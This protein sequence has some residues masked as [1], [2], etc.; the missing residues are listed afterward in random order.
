MGSLAEANWV[1]KMIYFLGITMQYAVRW[2]IQHNIT[3]KKK[4]ILWCRH[5]R[6]TCDSTPLAQHKLIPLALWFTRCRRPFS[7]T[8]T[9]LRECCAQ[10]QFPCMKNSCA[11]MTTANDNGMWIPSPATLTEAINAHFLLNR[12][13]WYSLRLTLNAFVYWFLALVLGACLIVSLWKA[14]ARHRPD[15][16]RRTN[17]IIYFAYMLIQSFCSFDPDR[18]QWVGGA[19]K[20]FIAVPATRIRLVFKISSRHFV[21]FEVHRMAWSRDAA[22]E[23][24]VPPY[25]RIFAIHRRN[26]QMRNL[27]YTYSW[28][29]L[30]FHNSIIYINYIWKSQSLAKCFLKGCKRMKNSI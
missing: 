10:N 11:Q 29:T 2:A 16:I 19:F 8:T 9:K 15:P 3:E 26:F 30:P 6:L 17:L 25:R 27:H 23:N 5:A 28:R 20:R 7:I 1:C 13:I 24:N 21:V 4:T 22:N 18:G 12:F 14:S